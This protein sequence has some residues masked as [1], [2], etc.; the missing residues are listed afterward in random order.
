MVFAFGDHER[1][2]DQL[3]D[4][5]E[6]IERIDVVTAD[7]RFRGVEGEAAREHAEAIQDHAVAFVEQVV[8][9]VDGSAQRLVTFHRGA[10]ASGEEPEP[11]VESSRDL[12]GAH[13]PGAC[14][15]EL[16][17]RE[18]SRRA[19][20]T[21]ARP[22]P[23]SRRRGRGD[24]RHCSARS[25]KS[26]TASAA[27]ISSVV[28]PSPGSG[29]ERTIIMRSPRTPEPLAPG[30]QHRHPRTRR[31]HRG[32]ELR[33]GVEEMLTVVEYHQQLL[34]S[35]RRHQTL[36]DRLPRPL[37]HPQRVGDHIGHLARITQRSQ[38]AQPDPIAIAGQDLRGGLHRESGLA[39][40]THADQGHHPALRQRLDDVGDVVV[41]PDERGH[42]QRQVG[43]ERIQRT[44]RREL[45]VEPGMHDLEDA[46]GL[47]Q[48][49]QVMR[50][51]VHQLDTEPRTSSWSP[52]TRGPGRRAPPTSTAPRDS[53]RCRNSHRRGPQPRRCVPPSAPATGR[54]PATAPPPTR[55]ARRSRRRP[56]RHA[57]ANTAW[58]PS[59]VVFTT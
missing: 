45:R 53:R 41:A 31:H 56:R 36:R 29:N 18:G 49:A 6:H 51:E 4:A 1:L 50:A 52:A 20:D 47:T 19:A 38:L 46:L 43:R 59:P 27:R 55:A 24:R 37:L 44:Q 54:S 42:L 16:D 32:D 5:V 2:V 22:S 25:V 39:H 12:L 10:A 30:G 48:V 14:R 7:H 35:Q 8:A 13:H 34:R 23:R 28:A 58:N 11:L 57:V 33:G 9:P 26:A 21:A 17:A 3:R 40:T 15:R